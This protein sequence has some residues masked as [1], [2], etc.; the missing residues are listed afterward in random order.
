VDKLYFHPRVPADWKSFKVHYRYR[1]THYHISVFPQSEV[2]ARGQRIVLDGAEQ[3]DVFVLLTDDRRI[4]QV[5]VHIDQ[6]PAA[7]PESAP[8]ASS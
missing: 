2:L 8:V 3:P 5:E 1:E 6:T 4:H 7:V